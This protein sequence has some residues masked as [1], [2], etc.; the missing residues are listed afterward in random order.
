MSAFEAGHCL[1]GI[2]SELLQELVKH[3]ES[4]S[5]AERAMLSMR[6]LSQDFKKSCADCAAL[7]AGKQQ[8][9]SSTCSCTCLCYA[10]KTI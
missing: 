10:L 6:K 4:D 1:Q 7:F 2:P 9:V 3:V 5:T 8:E